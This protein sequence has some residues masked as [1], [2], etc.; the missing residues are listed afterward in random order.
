MMKI[1]FDANFDVKN[2]NHLYDIHFQNAI[3][4]QS[5]TKEKASHLRKPKLFVFYLQGNND[6]LLSRYRK[7]KQLNRLLLESFSNNHI[8]EAD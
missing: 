6:T 3:N 4:A 7:R 2:A 8:L 5:N 1:G